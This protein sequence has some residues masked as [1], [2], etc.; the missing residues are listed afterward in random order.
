ML[1]VGGLMS[2]MGG[3]PNLGFEVVGV[4]GRSDVECGEG[5]MVGLTAEWRSG[6]GTVIAAGGRWA[7]LEGALA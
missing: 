1:L 6:M 5:A 4:V 3:A 7:E 2:A